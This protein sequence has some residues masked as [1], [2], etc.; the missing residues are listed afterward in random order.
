MMA[1]PARRREVLGRLHEAGVRVSI[2]DFG[3]GY[4][5]LA[6]LKDL[7]VDEVKI[8][9]T[10]VRDMWPSEKAACI[11]RSDHRPGPQP[12]PAGR[13]RGGRGPRQPGPAGLVGLR[14]RARA[15][16]FSRP[17]PAGDLGVA[18]GRL[19]GCSGMSDRLGGG[20]CCVL[21]E[22]GRREC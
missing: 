6:Y 4:S 16:Y 5:S 12:R 1:D 18:L 11:V 22:G 9:R 2:D 15:I 8:D 14:R 3:T 10:F 13:G 7:P 19:G 21:A 20:G 17:L